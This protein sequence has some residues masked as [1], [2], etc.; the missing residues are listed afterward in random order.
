MMHQPRRDKEGR[1]WVLYSAAL[2]EVADVRFAGVC[3]A[4]IGLAVGIGVGMVLGY[5]N[6][7]SA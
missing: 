1:L 2:Q 5:L 3:I 6:W 4:L 7:R